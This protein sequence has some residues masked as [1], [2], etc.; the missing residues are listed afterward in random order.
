MESKKQGKLLT[1]MQMEM[2]MEML[3]VRH[4]VMGKHP[5]IHLITSPI[6]INDCANVILAVGGRPICAEH[7]EEVAGIT[8]ISRA[9]GV[10]LANI[11]DA[12]LKSIE[13]SGKAARHEGI[14]SVIDVVGVTCSRLRMDAAASFI[15]HAHPAV[16]KGNASEITALT[17][18]IVLDAA[19]AKLVD[20]LPDENWSERVLWSPLTDEYLRVPR[21]QLNPIS[22][23][24]AKKLLD[25]IDHPEG[26]EEVDEDKKESEAG[27]VDAG[28][29][30]VDVSDADRVRSHDEASIRRMIRIASTL[31]KLAATTVLVSGEVDIIC[32]ERDAALCRNGVPELGRVTGTG[33]MLNALVDTYLSEAGSGFTASVL[34]VVTL[35]IAGEIA[36]TSHG[37]GSF[38]IGLIDALSLMT[39]GDIRKHMNLEFRMIP[40]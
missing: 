6:A 11:T 2:Q 37:L 17:R 26:K 24:E 4:A 27:S 5:L 22:E 18:R 33:C 16:I 15:E 12:R 23:R 3:A 36:D 13:I 40:A 29:A 25:F 9:L 38:H 14:P 20:E 7:P 32:D 19:H 34:A 28:E 35:G 39:D 10:S 30:G 31:S 21:I 8:E 1:E